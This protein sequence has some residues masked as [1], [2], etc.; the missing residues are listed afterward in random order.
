MNGFVASPYGRPSRRTHHNARASGMSAIE[1]SRKAASIRP[2]GAPIASECR[3]EN[4]NAGR[5]SSSGLIAA[6]GTALRPG[7]LVHDILGFPQRLERLLDGQENSR[8]E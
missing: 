7:C 5:K 8:V 1:T 3:S 6:A 2:A 4:S